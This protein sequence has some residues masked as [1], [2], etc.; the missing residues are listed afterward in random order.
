MKIQ[1]IKTTIASC[2]TASLFIAPIAMAEKPAQ[3]D[4]DMSK[5]VIKQ[6]M[7]DLKGE[8]VTAMKAGGPLNAIQACNT[9]AKVIAQQ[10]SEK[11]QISVG[12]TSLKLR[13]SANKPDAWESQVLADFDKRQAAGED[14]K[15]MAYAEVVTNDKGEKHF[16][17]MKAIP[18]GKPCLTCHGDKV[19]PE[20]LNKITEYYPEDQATGY[21]LGQVRGAFTI[22]KKLK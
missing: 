10:A 6:F 12:R 1:M 15:K 22:G 4:I 8:L 16:R 18:V 14:V 3:E 13:S 20:V 7:G 21:Q 2:L 11:N 17:F 9:K 5:K 19:K